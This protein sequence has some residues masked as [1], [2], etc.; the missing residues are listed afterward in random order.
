MKKIIYTK[1]IVDVLKIFFLTSFTLVSIIW[2]LQAVNFLDIV[3]EDGHSF[4]TYFSYSILNIPKIFS[5]TFLLSFFIAFYYVITNYEQ[6]NQLL[7]YWS[8]NI[9]KI[10]FLNF[11]LQIS[12]MLMLLLILVSFWLVPFTQD[13]ARL[14]IRSSNLDFFPSLIKPKQFIDTVKDLTVF[15]DSKNK[16]SIENIFLK[17]SSNKKNVQV[18]IAKNGNIINFSDE[19]LLLLKT[20]KIIST[21]TKQK[22]T[23]FNFDET[24][25]DLSKYS[26]KT[27]TDSKIQEISSKDIFNC[28]SGLKK[29]KKLIFINFECSKKIEKDLLQEMYK[30][31]FKP[32][33]IILIAS[34]VS[35]V[36]LKSHVQ[37]S[38]NKWKFAIF[39][40]GTFFV[41]LSEVSINL[42]SINMIN[43][44]FNILFIIITFLTLYYLYSIKSKKL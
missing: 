3:S 1:F 25:L 44:I 29:E 16:D 9:S 43:N 31:T 30:R 8:N 33:Y 39:L 17:D 12:F 2:I 19:K 26:T 28:L 10:N 20:G 38:Y 6:N 36:V 14:K 4:K 34:I 18:I 24:K 32:F 23:I 40:I 37:S 7:I 42:I 15:I 22:S 35:F 13:K 21:N 5:K 41:I 27:I 11:I